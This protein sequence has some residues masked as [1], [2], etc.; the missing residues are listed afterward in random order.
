MYSMSSSLFPLLVV[1]TWA[2]GYVLVEHDWYHRA[3]AHQIF[4]ALLCVGFSLAAIAALVCA[5]PRPEANWS[6]APLRRIVPHNP[7]SL[8]EPIV[9]R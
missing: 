3:P 8:D 4:A 9:G 7:S 5:M 1:G 6:A 2:A